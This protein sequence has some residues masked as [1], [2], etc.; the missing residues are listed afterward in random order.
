MDN[1]PKYIGFFFITSFSFFVKRYLVTLLIS[2]SQY[3]YFS[4]LFHHQELNLE[5]YDKQM[6]NIW[7][8]VFIWDT[9]SSE[10]LIFIILRNNV[11]YRN[12]WNFEKP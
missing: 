8:Q 6:W 2:L 5:E 3:I 12:I 7:S 4:R 10:S 9:K 1:C 11:I